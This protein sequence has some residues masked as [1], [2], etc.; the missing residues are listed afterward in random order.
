MQWFT[1]K[2]TRVCGIDESIALLHTFSNNPENLKITALHD[3][4]YVE[5]F[6]PV[7]K[8][9]GK[10]QILRSGLSV[11]IRMFLWKWDRSAWMLKFENQYLKIYSMITRERG[12]ILISGV[13]VN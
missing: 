8:V 4:D 2:P 9:I 12:Y 11:N 13:R 7:L 10:Y 3:G 1:R 5:P 6:E